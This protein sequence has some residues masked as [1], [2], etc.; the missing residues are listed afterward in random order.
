MLVVSIAGTLV[1][2]PNGEGDEPVALAGF[3]AEAAP[4]VDLDGPTI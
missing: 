4:L 1:G 2:D 3:G